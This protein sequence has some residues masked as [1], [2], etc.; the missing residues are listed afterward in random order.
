MLVELYELVFAD[1]IVSATM[2]K[3]VEISPSHIS[4]N[5]VTEYLAVAPISR[6]LFGDLVVE[7]QTT[8]E[9]GF[10]A[11]ARGHFSKK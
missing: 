9:G 11:V 4:L 5:R 3:G 10:S 1:S 2:P 8:T 7:M 6:K